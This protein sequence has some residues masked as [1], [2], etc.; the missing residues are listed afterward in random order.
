MQNDFFAPAYQND[1]IE[2]V[3]EFAEFPKKLEFT[4]EKAEEPQCHWM[5]SDWHCNDL[6]NKCFRKCRDEK[7]YESKICL[8]SRT[9]CV[10]AREEKCGDRPI[11]EVEIFNNN[12]NRNIEND[13]IDQ[14]APRSGVT[15]GNARARVL[16]IGTDGGNGENGHQMFHIEGGV[17]IRAR[18]IRIYNIYD[19]G[20]GSLPE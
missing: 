2:E 20:G 15:G 4:E 17:A 19:N 3:P 14:F 13:Y 12:L 10:W 11:S 5:G 6:D 9:H 18:D 8:C 16:R 7:T 1:E